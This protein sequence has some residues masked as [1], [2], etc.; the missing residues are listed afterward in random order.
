MSSSSLF[1]HMASS[2]E[3]CTCL[4]SFLLF[5]KR[6]KRVLCVCFS[7]HASAVAD[8][9]LLISVNWSQMKQFNEDNLSFCH[10]KL[11]K[12]L[13]SQCHQ[14][15]FHSFSGVCLWTADLVRLAVFQL[16]CSLPVSFST[17]LKGCE[18]PRLLCCR[19]C[20]AEVSRRQS[21]P[22]MKHL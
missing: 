20:R 5:Q 21:P 16:T 6:E 11:H 22:N 10:L 4:L 17:Q 15:A 19:V 18:D 8:L 9:E 3:H 1:Q 14:A 7:Q 12:V 13:S 2:N